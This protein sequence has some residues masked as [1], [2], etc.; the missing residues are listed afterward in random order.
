MLGRLL[1][2]SGSVEVVVKDA[3]K[4]T[5][6]RVKIPIDRVPAERLGKKWYPVMRTCDGSPPFP[7]VSPCL[8]ATPIV[9]DLCCCYRPSASIGRAGV[10]NWLILGCNLAILLLPQMISPEKN[11]ATF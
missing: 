4:R 3:K 5:L 2:G 7:A 11:V 1:N 8:A 6:G 10:E 9:G